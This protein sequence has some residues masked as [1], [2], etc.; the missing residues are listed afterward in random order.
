MSDVLTLY[1]ST[2]CTPCGAAKRRLTAAGIPFDEVNLEENPDVLAQLKSS[3][4]V[5]FVTTP[6]FRWHG[7]LRQ[8]DALTEIEREAREAA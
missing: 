4:G 1:T 2:T 8:I 5:P 6:L 7:K 3:L